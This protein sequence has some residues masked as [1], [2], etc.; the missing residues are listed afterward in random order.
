MGG[1]RRE[2]K[3]KKKISLKTC[4][5]ST[6]STEKYLYRIFFSF[7]KKKFFVQTKFSTDFLYLKLFSSQ[8]FFP[9]EEKKITKVF[10]S[11]SPNANF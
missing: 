3:K 4:L 9:K 2:E 7:F 5:P 11:S 8:V 10:F 6:F 1:G